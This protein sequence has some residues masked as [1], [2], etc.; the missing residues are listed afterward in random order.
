MS[1]IQYKDIIAMTMTHTPEQL[2]RMYLQA[3]LDK[4]HLREVAMQAMKA[5]EDVRDMMHNKQQD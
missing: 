1:E 3:E 2:A 4:N 5:L